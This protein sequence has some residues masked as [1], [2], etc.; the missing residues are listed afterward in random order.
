MNR[1]VRSGKALLAIT[2]LVAI[3][4]LGACSSSSSSNGGDKTLTW[5]TGSELG[6]L[7]VVA[8]QVNG[9]A[10]RLLLGSVNEGLTKVVND[11]DKI[12]WEP[13]LATKWER[14]APKQWRFTLRDDVT[15]HDGS[16]MTSADVAYTINKLAD[17]KSAKDSTL[18]N[19][20]GAKVV[21]DHTVDVE[22]LVP[23][24]FTFR[25]MAAIGIQPEGWGKDAAAAQDTA[26]GT[27]PYRV[28]DVSASHDTATLEPYEK[29]W[30]DVKP[31]YMKVQM[32]VVPDT[33]A[34]LAGLK[35][36]ETDVAFD[37]SPDLLAAAPATV[38]AASTEIDILR[39][40]DATPALK[41]VRVRQA[42]NYAVDRSTFID[43][44]RFGFALPPKGQGVTKQVHGHNPDIEDYPYDLAKAKQLVKDAGAEGA[45]LTM[46]CVSEYYGTVGTD[47]C[48]TLA[49]AYNSIGLKVTVQML[50]RD[51][52]IE[53]GL[54]APQ[55]KIPPPDLFYVQ[56]GSGTLDSTLYI[57]NYYTC[58]DVRAT[59]CDPPLR[60]AAE[61]ALA[62]TDV[63]GQAA[64]YE[65][66]HALAHDVAPMVWITSPK[67][68]AAAQK[69]I[70]G[71]LYSDAY[72]VY[73][74]EWAAK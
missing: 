17:P 7:D 35:A 9:T 13:L 47:T 67:N 73:W 54:L 5:S 23:D 42:L 50:P 40:S 34:R 22:T 74:Y 24:F 2:S 26:V 11:H 58:G 1:A 6:T 57:Q 33:G 45:K 36:N 41:D 28:T 12:S 38:E 53:Q 16:A 69:D 49:S 62:I 8:D 68:V 29:Y 43:D 37:L 64:A 66:V 39:I 51:K 10:R 31:H 25:S 55:N 63:A 4:A 19:I 15:F 14:V 21:D 56:A 72:T 71:Q 32:K 44:I 46:M 48:E 52:W 59:L 20:A 70:K 27:G 30:G 61:K 18:A 3:A 65:Q 60:D